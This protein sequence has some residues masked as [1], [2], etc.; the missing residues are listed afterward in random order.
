MFVIILLLIT[1]GMIFQLVA[2]AMQ[3]SSTEQAKTDMVQEGREFMDQLA[4]DL[5]AAGYPS[6]ET[7]ASSG[8]L[9]ASPVSNDYRG[10]VGLV[11]VDSGE[12]WLEGDMDGSGT[13]SVVH[14]HLDTST[15]NNCPCL[16]RSQQPKITGDPVTGQNTPVYQ[17]E[18]Q[19]VQ[20]TNIF[21]AYTW[22]STGTAVSLPVDFDSSGSAIATID[23]IKV[24][25]TLQA[26]T[27]DPKTNQYPISTLVSTVKL[28]NCSQAA[29]GLTMSCQ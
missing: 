3:R 13:V 2:L 11:K 9:T 4:M 22:A 12:L 21:S 24:I 7:L 8:V 10:A 5:R 23:T 16:R 1:L 26:L 18:V 27:P 15:G 20:N 14:Y 6:P 17:M 19:N 28:Q 25:L 29:T